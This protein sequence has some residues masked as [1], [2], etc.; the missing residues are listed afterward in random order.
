MRCPTCHADNQ[1]GSFVCHSCLRPLPLTEGGEV[2]MT[3]ETGALPSRR[4][5]RQPSEWTTPIQVTLAI[6]LVLSAVVSVLALALGQEAFTRA[7]V[8]SATARGTN[9]S[10]NELTSTAQISYEGVL[11]VTAFVS[12][13]KALLAA[14]GFMRWSW[15]YITD[16]VLLAVSAVS[17]LGTLL[18][19]PSVATSGVLLGQALIPLILDLAGICLFAW[20]AVAI[21][22]YGI[23]ACRKIP[24]AS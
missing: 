15:V 10:I 13:L 17:T 23:W 8:L 22:R 9:L 14:G 5:V 18:L 16:M 24:V 4:F 19:I 12:A 6:Y 21:S 3:V 1:T 7:F 2:P 20:M 11:V